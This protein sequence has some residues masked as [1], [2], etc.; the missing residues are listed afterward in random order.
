MGLPPSV[1]PGRK[2]GLFS[3]LVSLP[4]VKAVGRNE[5]PAQG[6][7]SLLE[8][9]WWGLLARGLACWL[10]ASPFFPCSLKAGLTSSTKEA[11]LGTKV[12]G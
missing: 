7:V 5:H 10:R 12:V 3:N 8:S 9:G 2:G 4:W 6:G 11:G 1:P